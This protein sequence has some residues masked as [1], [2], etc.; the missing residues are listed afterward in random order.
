MAKIGVGECLGFHALRGIDDQQSAFAGRKRAR[1]FIRKINVAGRID[2]VELIFL[3]VLGHVL[4]PHRVG[5]DGDS[6]LTLQVHR[7]QH[8]FLHLAQGERS[9]QLQE[10]VRKRGFAM[11]DVGDDGKISDVCAVHEDGLTVLF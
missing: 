3:T 9:R 2:Q 5:L 8:L 6:A 4:H 1:N 7:V 11:I 10:P